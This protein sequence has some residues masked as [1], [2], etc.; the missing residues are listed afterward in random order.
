MWLNLQDSKLPVYASNMTEALL[1]YT[2]VQD[3]VYKTCTIYFSLVNHYA[4]RLEK[5]SILLLA[6]APF[7][8]RRAI[9]ALYC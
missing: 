5:G 8:D 3:T 1:S 6:L 7:L 4:C 9:Y 2:S